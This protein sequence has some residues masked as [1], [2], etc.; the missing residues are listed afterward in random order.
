MK[1]WKRWAELGG[2]FCWK[3]EIDAVGW[4]LMGDQIFVGFG[5]EKSTA[6]YELG[7][8][9]RGDDRDPQKTLP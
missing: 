2:H 8:G 1:I 7:T 9:G 5:L 6:C 3:S 4:F